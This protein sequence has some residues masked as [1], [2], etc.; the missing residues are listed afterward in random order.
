MTPA[1]KDATPNPV[2]RC[3]HIGIAGSPV[4]SPDG[5]RI[6]VSGG[7]SA[8]SGTYLI[9][10]TEGVYVMNADGSGLTRIW[11]GWT[12]RPSWRPVAR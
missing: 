3:P 8:G 12:A 7:E 2:W 9:R 4:W 6:A 1:G 10:G 5:R 11:D